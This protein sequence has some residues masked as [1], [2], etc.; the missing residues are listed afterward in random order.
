MGLTYPVLMGLSIKAVPQARRASAMGAFQ[1][2]YALGM[3]LGPALSGFIADQVTLTAIF[4]VTA[5]MCL[6]GLLPI[7]L[8]AA[9]IRKE[10]ASPARL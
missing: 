6:V 2:I 10:Q 3:T 7:W 5:A 8:S 1:A 9:A 4:P